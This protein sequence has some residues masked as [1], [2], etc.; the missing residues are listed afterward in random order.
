[1]QQ[2]QN[3]IFQT[4]AASYTLALWCQSCDIKSKTLTD[5]CNNTQKQLIFRYEIRSTGK[6]LEEHKYPNNITNN[7]LNFCLTSAA[8]I[9]VIILKTNR[10]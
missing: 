6:K 9:S 2:K 7:S 1:M 10:K 3:T 5:N 4:E 8:Y